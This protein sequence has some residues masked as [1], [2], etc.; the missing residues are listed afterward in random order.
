MSDARGSLAGL[1]HNGADVRGVVR[2]IARALATFHLNAD[3]SYA[4]AEAGRADTVR[5]RWGTALAVL[6]D[7]APGCMDLDR[8]ELVAEL[9][10]EYVEGRVALF[11]HRAL[12]DRIVECHGG[13]TGD[14]IVALTPDVVVRPRDS[15]S[16]ASRHMDVL[17]EVAAVALE[18]EYLGHASASTQLLRDY[19]E[20]T[21]DTF[22]ASLAHHYI[23]QRAVVRS[24]AASARSVGDEPA[25]GEAV[26]MLDLA[27]RHLRAAQVTWLMVGGPPGVG[28][29][30]V[31]A[32]LADK[33]GWT[34]IRSDEVRRQLL[35]ERSWP[36]SEWLSEQFSSDNTAAVYI[37]MVRRAELL[38]GMGESVA[39]DATWSSAPL[40][41]MTVAAARTARCLHVSVQCD[42]PSSV[43]DRRVERR[44]AAGPDIAAA[45]VAIARRVRECFDPWPDAIVVNTSQPLD[46]SVDHA[47]ASAT[48]AVAGRRASPSP[49]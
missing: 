48:S 6:R 32:R 20:F 12:T 8:I 28:K 49:P 19:A 29:S 22:P 23:A 15:A 17:S 1:L 13:T 18:L 46:E 39:M 43:A 10:A 7:H 37:E 16:A 2:D 38:G 35:G 14:D 9:A 36:A 5:E 31:A 26:G 25:A 24:G 30:S 11:G 42:A 47:L 3:C 21:A 4:V 34:V 33:L 45:T 40:R 44:I 27:L 41:E